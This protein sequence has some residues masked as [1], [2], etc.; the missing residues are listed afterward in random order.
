M[1]MKFRCV[2]LVF[3][4]RNN[5]LAVFILAQNPTTLCLNKCYI[6]RRMKIK[7]ILYGFVIPRLRGF[8]WK[9]KGSYLNCGI[10][11]EFVEEVSID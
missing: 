6:N 5:E 2:N 1:Q 11:G 7:R 9:Q 4:R 8:R 10:F 3:Y